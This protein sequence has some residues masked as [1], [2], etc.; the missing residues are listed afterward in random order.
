MHTSYG[1]LAVLGFCLLLAY[2]L[3]APMRAGQEDQL[4]LSPAALRMSVGD[5]YTV[6]CALASDAPGQSLKFDS[7]DVR[8]ASIATDGTVYALAPGEAVITARASGG[9]HAQMQVQVRGVPMSELT[10]NVDELHIAKG[11][12]SGLSVRYNADASDTRLQWISSDEGI[13]R[14]DQAGRVEGVSGGSAY[15][16]VIT[17]AGRSAS[18]RVYVDVPGTAMRIAPAEL[19]LGV[20]ARVQLSASYLPQDCTDSVRS[21]VSS[22]PAVARVDENGEL[23]AVGEGRVYISA[24][25][26]GGLTG[27]ME[28]TVEAAPE[29]IQLDPSRATLERGDTVQM[30][31]LFL[32]ADGSVDYETSHP[33]VWTSSDERVATVDQQGQ[34]TA[35][36]S[37]DCRI[38]ASADG[39]TASCRLKVQVTI[40]EITLDQQEI[41]LLKEQAATP[42]QL[43]WSIAPVDADDPTVR[44]TS[45]NEQVATVSPEGLVRMTGGYGTA[46]ITAASESGAAASF[47]VNVVTQLPQTQPEATPEPDEPAATAEPAATDDWMDFGTQMDEQDMYA[48]MEFDDSIDFDMYGGGGDSVG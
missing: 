3:L 27:G 29:D 5:S 9:A 2:L 39:M 13:A 12:I 17:P 16:S 34:V 35:L 4:M 1:K 15:I 23:R 24:L 30:Q 33:V 37:G 48:G 43:H 46:V 36:S 41:Y 19:T 31:L 40:H 47:T 21:W 7:S 32:N 8:V 6:R 26:T 18:A 20:G 38:E 28:V 45:N 10:L 42:I 25:S 11:E 14:V 22:D 44:F